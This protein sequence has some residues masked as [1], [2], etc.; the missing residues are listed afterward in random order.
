MNKLHAMTAFVQIVDSG[1]LTDAAEVL[2]TSLPTVVR[3]LANLEAHLN[4]R[5]LNR[6]TRKITLTEEGRGY[7]ENCRRILFDVTSAELE[8]SAQQDK[9][10]GKLA[11]T[12]SVM[13]GTI[14]IA[15]LLNRFLL[16][17]PSVNADLILSDSNMNLVEDGVDVAI[18]IG[19]LADSSLIA[20]NVG[21]VRRLICGTPKLLN[22]LP[23]ITKPKD[24]QNVPC[25]LFSGLNQ[26]SHWQVY[27]D[28]KP[29]SL[30][31]T[32]PLSCNQLSV[33]IDA[34]RKSMGLGTFLS[35]QVEDLIEAGELQVVLSEF[36][37]PLLPVSVVYSHTKLMSTRVRTFVD[38]IVHELRKELR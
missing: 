21:Y 33:S 20:K 6:T 4:T 15:P 8:L 35:Y 14:S 3:T 16:K 24:L 1:S 2:D 31:V 19:P 13:F 11:I 12:A 18:R 27:Q 28:K 10:M 30:V 34:V 9:P 32:G 26:G 5:L 22:T 37:P 36:E 29:L 38:W 23:K 25:I 7:L 17:Y